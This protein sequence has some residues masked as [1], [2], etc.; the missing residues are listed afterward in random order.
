MDCQE[1]PSK[2]PL[3]LPENNSVHEP[4]GALEVV[5]CRELH[6]RQ[7]AVPEETTQT[8]DALQQ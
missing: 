5:L 4:S 6:T 8:S 7:K 2:I 1:S 3:R